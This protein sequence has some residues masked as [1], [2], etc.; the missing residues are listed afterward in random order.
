[1]ISERVRIIVKG[2]HL[3]G[4][5]GATK[6]LLRFVSPVLWASRLPTE[7]GER[8][9]RKGSRVQLGPLTGHPNK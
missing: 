2:K 3:S 5:L 4:S 7:G 9:M 6:E 8:L 1:M